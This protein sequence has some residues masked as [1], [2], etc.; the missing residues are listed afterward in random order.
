M[1][2]SCELAGRSAVGI[3]VSQIRQAH[4]SHLGP[5][6][7]APVALSARHGACAVGTLSA[8]LAPVDVMCVRVRCVQPD[9]EDDVAVRLED[10]QNINQ[11]G[12]LNQRLHDL[13]EDLKARQS[14]HELLDDASN[15]IILADDDEPVR[16]INHPCKNA[17]PVFYAFSP[18]AVKILIIIA[19]P[20][21][22]GTRL[23]SATMR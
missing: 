18:L 9:D 6:A 10:Q 17:S 13:E 15:E 2:W 23:E 8:A 22:A 16:S 5:N 20:P 11:F 12:R 21:F 1:G 4:V 7:K 14:K 19:T 3:T